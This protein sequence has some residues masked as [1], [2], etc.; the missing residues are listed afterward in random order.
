MELLDL[1]DDAVWFALNSSEADRLLEPYDQ[2]DKEMPAWQHANGHRYLK[3]ESY[4]W[5]LDN[6]GRPNWDWFIKVIRNDIRAVFRDRD[7]A[8]LFK[9]TF[10]G[11]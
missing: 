2:D 3:A 6:I 5:L 10:G 8:M 9:M 1:E 4:E 11:K 7:K